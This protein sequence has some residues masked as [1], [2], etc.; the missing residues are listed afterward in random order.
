[1]AVNT[2]RVDAIV[3]QFAEEEEREKELKKEEEMKKEEAKNKELAEKEEKEERKEKEFSERFARK[4]SEHTKGMED[5]MVALE[6]GFG[7]ILD[8]CEKNFSARKK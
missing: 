1:M 3:R 5:R 8:M 2:A 7:K 6:E 4:F